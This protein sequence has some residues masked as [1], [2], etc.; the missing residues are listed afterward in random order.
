MATLQEL[1]GLFTNS[2]LMEKVEA[3]LL[4]SVQAVLGGTPTIDDQKYASH[5]FSNPLDEARKALMSVLASNSIATVIQI[6]TATD[7][8]IQTNVDD[9]RA[10]LSVAWNAAQIPQI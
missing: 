9:V 5:V 7:A 10:T 8:S 3:A 6:T 2:N 1:R 4:I